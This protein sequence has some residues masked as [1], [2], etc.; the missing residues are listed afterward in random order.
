M[1]TYSPLHTLHVV[2]IYIKYIYYTYVC[3]NI[4][5]FSVSVPF[6]EDRLHVAISFA[7]NHFT[8]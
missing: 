4:S 8:A 1:S 3:I 5:R 2:Y 6:G 7:S